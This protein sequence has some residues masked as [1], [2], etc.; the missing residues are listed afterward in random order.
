MRNLSAFS[1]TLIAVAPLMAAGCSD[2][3]GLSPSAHDAD[4]GTTVDTGDANADAKGQPGNYPGADLGLLPVAPG[5]VRYETQPLTVP[6]GQD[7]MWE[8]W[9]APPLESDMDAVEV[10]GAQTKGGH[11]A[12]LFAT[13]DLQP[14]GTGRA[15]QD[16][17]QLASRTLGGTGG[18]ADSALKL[19]PGVVF[20]VL[21]G[22]ALMIQTH[23]LNASEQPIVGRSVLDVKLTPV[24]PAARVATLLT[25]VTINISIPPGQRTTADFRCTI[26]KEFRVLKYANHMHDWGISASTELIGEDGTATPLQID[27]AWDPSWA[28][29]PNYTEFTLDAPRVLPA[30][31]TMH[32]TCTWGNSGNKTLTFPDEMC[33]F[34][35]IYLGDVDASCVDGVWR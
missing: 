18:E 30:G 17:D 27:A 25:N 1:T 22:S 21:K 10:R 15:W 33:I 20:R 8:E 3:N 6:P 28:F 34:A 11:H 2:S 29:H 35:G 24:D 5:F 4:A 12:N 16:A 32:T 9:V 7:I 26:D 31:S 23:Y 14:V 19:P 13:T